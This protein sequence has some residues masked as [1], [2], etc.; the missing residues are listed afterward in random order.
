MDFELSVRAVPASLP[1]LPE[2]L[3]NI[4][5]QNGQVEGWLRTAR[6]EEIVESDYHSIPEF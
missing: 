4:N 2:S 1:A 3:N 5:D 6:G